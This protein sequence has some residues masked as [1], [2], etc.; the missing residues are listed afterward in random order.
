MSDLALTASALQGER[1]R[2]RD[3]GMDDVVTKPTT[4]DILAGTLRSWLPDVAWPEADES[5]ESNGRG[6]QVPPAVD[7]SALEEMVAGD[8]EL[9]AQ[10]LASYAESVREDLLGLT[11]ALELGDRE[12]LRRRAHQILGASRVVG[13]WAVADTAERME[14]AALAEETGAAD[15]EVLLHELR[16][17]LVAVMPAGR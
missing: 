9:G 1:E 16:N 14:H 17:A 7:G 11:A 15:L 13:A 4:M 8:E 3:A 10:I 6:F 5:A 12:D 2:C